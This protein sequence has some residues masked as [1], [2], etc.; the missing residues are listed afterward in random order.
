MKHLYLVALASVTM[1][2]SCD[3]FIYTHKNRSQKRREK[4]S[5]FICEQIIDFRVEEGRWPYSKEDLIHKGKKYYDAFKDFKYT[6]TDFKIKD[7]N[8]M[9]FYFEDHIAD[10]T[11]YQL[12]DRSELNAYGGRIRFFRVKDKFAYKIKMR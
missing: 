3:Y 10:E 5:I 9:T 4:P 11:T 8:N 1:L 12:T 7:S 2:V 6:W